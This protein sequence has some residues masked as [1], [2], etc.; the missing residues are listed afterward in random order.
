MV[1]SG[2]NAGEGTVRELGIDKCVHTAVFKMNNQEG[3]TL[4][5]RALCLMSCDRLDGRGV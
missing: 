3:P 1:T 2:K 5:R 4:W